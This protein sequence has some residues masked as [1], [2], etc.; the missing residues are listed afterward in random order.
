MP[1][2]VMFEMLIDVLQHTG[3]GLLSMANKGPNTN[4]SQFF[5]T[6]GPVYTYDTSMLFAMRWFDMPS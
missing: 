1:Y 4:T 2:N 6:L 3:R 5:I